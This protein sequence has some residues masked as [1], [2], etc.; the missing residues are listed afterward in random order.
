MD[1]VESLNYNLGKMVECL[2]N[3]DL[4]RAKQWLHRVFPEV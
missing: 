1:K 4:E 2:N 3:N